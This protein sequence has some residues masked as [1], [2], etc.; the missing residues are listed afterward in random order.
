MDTP[1]V[2][3]LLYLLTN[4]QNSKSLDSLHTI[5]NYL[6]TI[7]IDSNYTQEK[8]NIA[9]KVGPLLPIEYGVPFNKS[10]LIT[11]KVVK[12][13]E[14]MDFLRTSETPQLTT[15]ELEPKARLQKIVLTIQEEVNSSKIENLGLV[16][17][18][19]INM[20]KYKKMFGAFNS[21]MN[22][23]NP[24]SDTNSIMNILE[25][26]MGGSSEKDKEKIKEMYKMMDLLKI[27]DMPRKDKPNEV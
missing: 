12:I 25:T 27:L 10:I 15:L 13:M 24:L 5:K 14:L 2:L 20:E 22:T 16:L 19:L 6:T 1:V 23:K 3:I 7:E 9:K 21:L 18:L 8:I 26:F 4:D 11:Q 17:D